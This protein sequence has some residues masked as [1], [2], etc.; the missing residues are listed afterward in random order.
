M[1]TPL[2]VGKCA[3]QLA[4]IVKEM[5]RSGCLAATRKTQSG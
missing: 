4:L 3:L 2:G 1:P 5:S